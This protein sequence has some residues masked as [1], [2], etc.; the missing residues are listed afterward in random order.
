MEVRHARCRGRLLCQGSRRPPD[1]RNGSSRLQPRLSPVWAIPAW[2][3]VKRQTISVCPRL[4][5][6]R[7]AH[8]VI[9]ASTGVRSSIATDRVSINLGDSNRHRNTTGP[10]TASSVNGRRVMRFIDAGLTRVAVDHCRGGKR[11]GPDGDCTDTM[12]RR[13]RTARPPKSK[14]A[15]RRWP[16]WSG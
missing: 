5:L 14:K 16:F 13:R 6:R 4:P 8:D 9:C 2:T 7:G 1:V 3:N 10:A 12:M 15:T 11:A